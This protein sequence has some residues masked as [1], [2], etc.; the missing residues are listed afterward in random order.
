MKRL[1]TAA[2]GVPIALAAL[3]YFPGWL[4]FVFIAV[5]VEGAAWEYL[6]IVRPQAPHAPLGVFLGLVPL[7]G[8]GLAWALTAGNSLA[9]WGGGADLALLAAALLGS[10]VLGSFVLLARVPLNE[11]VASL[12][13]LGFGTPYLALPLASMYLLQRRDPWLVFLLMAIVW[14]GD[15]AAYY[16]GSRLG[17]HKMAPTVSPKKSWEGAAAGFLV[18]VLSAAVWSVWRLGRLSLLLLA[19]A[20]VTALAAQVGDLVESLLKRGSGVKDSGRVL[21]GHGGFLDRIDAMLFAAP[22]LLAG[23]LLGA[24]Q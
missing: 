14:L 4:F 12:G 2:V 5:F 6:E 13:I 1:L 10:V 22:V 15:T 20:A 11:I 18:S 9:R 19:L 21:P 8:A 3:F 16:A 23:V 7:V 24:V 17:R